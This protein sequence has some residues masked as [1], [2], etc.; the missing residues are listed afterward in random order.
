MGDKFPIENPFHN[1][2]NEGTSHEQMWGIDWNLFKD[3]VHFRSHHQW[4]RHLSHENE[5]FIK[6][7]FD[8]KD[9]AFVWQLVMK[10]TGRA[11]IDVDNICKD[12]FHKMIGHPHPEVRNIISRINAYKDI[13]PYYNIKDESWPDITSVEEF[14]RLPKEVIE[15]CQNVYNFYPVDLSASRPDSPR[16]VLRDLFKSWFKNK[17][18]SPAGAMKQFDAFPNVYKFNLDSFYNFDSLQA[19]LKNIKRFFDLDLK[20]DNFPKSFHDTFVSRVPFRDTRQ[21]CDRILEAIDRR[22]DIEINL[23]VFCEGYLDYLIEEKFC[24]KMPLHH[25]KYFSSSLK[26]LNYIE[27]IKA[28][29]VESIPGGT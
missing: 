27:T 29:G 5:K 19:E 28:K 18:T 6:I 2:T 7:D 22:E 26:I 24:I 11:S 21:Q 13:S 3:E 9:D 14:Y 1:A 15:E 25:E 23:N 10:R 8:S 16:W 17:D 20:L 4:E 12:T